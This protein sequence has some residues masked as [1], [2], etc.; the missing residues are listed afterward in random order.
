M[1]R[2][3]FEERYRK[4][5]DELAE[6]LEKLDRLRPE[7]DARRFPELYRRVCHQLSL[8]RTRAYGR[9][10]ELR[11]NRLVLQGHQH[12]YR[13]RSRSRGTWI[14]MF[15]ST[16]PRA[17]RAEWRLFWIA[18]A[19]LYLPLIAMHAAVVLKPELVYS[20]MSPEQVQGFE[21]MYRTSSAVE[22]ERP[23]DSDFMMFGFYIYNNISIAFRTFAG[24]ILF[25][26]GSIFF[27]VYNGV[28]MGAAS[29]HLDVVGSSENLYSFA[30]GH[31][32]FELTAIVLAGATGLRLG[33]SLLM[34]GSR[35]RAVALRESARELL[36][37]VFGMTAFLIVAAF[38][39]AFWSSRST[40]PEV[41]LVVGAVLWG[42][43][44]FY[45]LRAGRS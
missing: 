44:T 35:P 2:E 9:D 22:E 18:T 30:I 3:S 38:I 34:P 32:A 25:G 17:V 39:E 6:L 21:A 41:R 20:V 7:V 19:L 28:A 16:F 23:S 8:V 10:L 43:V 12:L 29:G 26:V 27:L 4:D 13:E 33:S 37:I 1:N 24:G 15:L 11:L 31:G 5:W 42:M 14:R 45:L 40:E 36:P